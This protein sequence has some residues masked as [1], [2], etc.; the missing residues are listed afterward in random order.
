MLK[1]NSRNEALLQRLIE[2]PDMVGDYSQETR[3]SARR[4]RDFFVRERG[5]SYSDL[6]R[7][8][9]RDLQA[10]CTQGEIRYCLTEGGIDWSRKQDDFVLGLA[11]TEL[12]NAH[13]LKRRQRLE[14]INGRE[15]VSELL[16]EKTLILEKADW[17]Y[18]EK[19][20]ESRYGRNDRK[21]RGLRYEFAKSICRLLEDAY[22]RDT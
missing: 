13:Y 3:E 5:W 17:E 10:L 18:L 15:R 21:T 6:K 2:Q 16:H 1:P 8:R 22:G 7:F 20:V 11:L 19:L 9:F 14:H 12:K 4:I